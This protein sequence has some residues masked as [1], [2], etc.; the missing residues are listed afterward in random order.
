MRS[1]QTSLEEKREILKTFGALRANETIGLLVELTE[2]EGPLRA[3][4]LEALTEVDFRRALTVS[5]ETI[6]T[7][8]DV[9][10]QAAA[11]RVL[12]STP[13]RAKFAGTLYAD[14]RLPVSLLPVVSEAL[15]KHADKDPQVADVLKRVLAGGLALSL[16]PQEVKRVEEMVATVGRPQNGMG[17]FLDQNKVSCVGCHTLEG[18]GGNTGP[19][20]TKVWE[21]H[22]IPK[23]LESMI[24]PS[25]EIKEGYQAFIVETSQGRVHAGLKVLDNDQEVVIRDAQGKETRIAKTDIESLE[26]DEKSLMPDNV[27][28]LLN[29]QEFIDLVAFL[30]DR[31]AQETL[32]TRNFHWWVAGLYPG[33]LETAYPPEENPDPQQPVNGAD[34]NPLQWRSTLV[35]ANGLLDLGALF[36][37]QADVSAYAL[38][39]VHSPID[40]KAVLSVGSNDQCR[41]WLNG[42]LVHKH[43]GGRTARPDQDKVRST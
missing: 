16:D 24:D 37:E 32:R 35:S 40:Q 36:G 18:V 9:T 11:I 6:A 43:T 23:I 22:S 30:K 38:T 42:E 12:G 4:A 33:E 1:E 3:D 19:D 28:A 17:V 15:R 7:T 34:G 27:I 31:D 8:N 20:L 41:I 10:Y 29:Y 2:Q 14:R 25:K 5:S 21:T 13:E 26:P 39:Y